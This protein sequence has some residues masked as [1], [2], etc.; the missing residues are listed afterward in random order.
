MIQWR[1]RSFIL[2]AMSVDMGAVFGDGELV[3]LDMCQYCFKKKL[4]KFVR[5]TPEGEW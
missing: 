3:E 5:I 4:G 2:F 1:F